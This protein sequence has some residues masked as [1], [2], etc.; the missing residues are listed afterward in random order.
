MSRAMKNRRF[1]KVFVESIA[2]LI[3]LV[4]KGESNGKQNT[5]SKLQGTTSQG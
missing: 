2:I 3:A 1:I 4:K 5:Y